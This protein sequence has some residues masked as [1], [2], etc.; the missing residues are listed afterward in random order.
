MSSGTGSNYPAPV[1]A[2]Q[3]AGINQAFQP[4]PYP[5]TTQ[6]AN[7]A[8]GGIQNLYNPATA[9]ALSGAGQS[10]VNYG[11]GLP[12]QLAPQAQQSLQRG[13]SVYDY[14]VGNAGMPA[15]SGIDQ[16]NNLAP[17]VTKALQQGF[18]PQNALYNRQFQQ[19][20]Q[21]N[22]ASQAMAG[23]GQSP[24]AAGLTAQGNEN[25]NIDW[26]NQQLARQA[27]AAQTAGG[28]SSTAMGDLQSG[29][30]TSAN[31]LNTGMNAY[32]QGLQGANQTTGLGISGMEGLLGAGGNAI[33][34]AMGLNQQ[35]IQ[36]YL[37]YLS[38]STQNAAAATGQQLGALNAGTNLFGALNQGNLANQQLTN[39]SLGGLGA[40]GGTALGA[41][42]L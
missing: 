20:Q 17:F 5:N 26:Q 3:S 35:Q 9:S 27:Q 34:Q 18:D 38:G 7:S 1:V 19:Q 21:Q 40:L 12:G 32:T 6:A 11:Q 30:G 29:F 13:G 23:V 2:G 24:Y 14:A 33:A 10:A 31:L 22:L 25:F 41:L 37:A 8:F 36:D 28:L 42:L 39:A 16:Y 15:Y 4:F